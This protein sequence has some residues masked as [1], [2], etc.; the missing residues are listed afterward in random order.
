MKFTKLFYSAVIIL[1]TMGC[2]QGGGNGESGSE[3][4]IDEDTAQ[5]KEEASMDKQKE[6]AEDKMTNNGITLTKVTSPKFPEA[7]LTLNKPKQGSKVSQGKVKFDF[8]VAN[9]ELKNQTP[10]A[11]AKNCANSKKGQH[12]HLIL[13]NRPY[14]A[15][16]DSSFTK[17]MDEAHYV[18]LAFLSRSYHESIKQKKARVLTQFTVGDAEKKDVDLSKPHLFFSRPKGTYLGKDTSNVLLDFYVANAE[19]S[20]DG[21]KVR[22]KINDT[23]SFTIAKWQPYFINGLP[24]GDHKIKL[25][26]IDQEGNSVKSP[27]NPVERKITLSADEPLDS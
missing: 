13:N 10:D 12:I 19:L 11:K 7:T 17:D 2:S 23:T 5:Q 4:G 1:A 15:Y 9:Y 22:A 24:T 18:V 14:T 16:Y 27:F 21:Y 20:K 25:E 3:A 8:G 26:L 6:T